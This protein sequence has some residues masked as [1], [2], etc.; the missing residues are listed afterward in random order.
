VIHLDTGFLIKSLVRG[1]AED[2][3]LPDWLKPGEVV[4][5]SAA[6]RDRQRP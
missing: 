6:A 1:S 2:R 4:A 5:M 3:C